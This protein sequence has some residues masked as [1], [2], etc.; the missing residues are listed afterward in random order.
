[1]SKAEPSSFLFALHFAEDGLSSMPRCWH[2]RFCVR[3][4]RRGGG[5]PPYAKFGIGRN[6]YPHCVGRATFSPP[7]LAPSI[8]L[9][10]ASKRALRRE[11]RALDEH[12]YGVRR[13]TVRNSRRDVGIAPYAKV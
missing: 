8:L 5:T 11:E 12:P 3:N 1:M 6:S 10:T 2:Y 4:S 9:Q 13:K 7:L